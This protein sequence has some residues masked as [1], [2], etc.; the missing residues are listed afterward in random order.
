MGV[1]GRRHFHFKACWADQNDCCEL[2]AS[3]W[4]IYKQCSAMT[5]MVATNRNC[6]LDDYERAS[7][8]LVNNDKSEMCVS[9]AVSRA[10]EDQLAVIIGVRKFFATEDTLAWHY[11]NNGKYTIRSGYH[12]EMTL[13]SASDTSSSSRTSGIEFARDTSLVPIV[14]ES[15][16]LRVVMLVNENDSMMADIGL[17]MCD[18]HQLL[19]SVHIESVLYVS[20]KANVVTHSLVKMALIITENCFRIEDYLPSLEKCIP[21][22]LPG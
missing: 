22:D 3:N 18:I 7:R 10:E 14:I 12:L 21:E 6:I 9:K 4:L 8:Q 1:D 16:A 15:D 11:T 20:R 19:S 13:L 5:G 17:I 2:V